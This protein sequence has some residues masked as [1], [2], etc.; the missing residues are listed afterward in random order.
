MS[1]DVEEK[2]S[3]IIANIAEKSGIFSVSMIGGDSVNITVIFC[4]DTKHGHQRKL[5]YH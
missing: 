3:K 4:R 1:Q 2:N 5:A